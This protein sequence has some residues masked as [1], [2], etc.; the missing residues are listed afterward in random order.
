MHK[1]QVAGHRQE[2]V[3]LRRR[4]R[5]SCRHPRYGR[6]FLLGVPPPRRGRGNA[7]PGVGDA[8]ST[9][10]RRSRGRPGGGRHR[11]RRGPAG[12]IG[13]PVLPPGGARRAPPAVLPVLSQRPHAGREPVAR[14][15]RPRRGGR[16][17]GAVGEGG[18][19]AARGHDAPAR[20]AAAAGGRL[21]RSPGLAGGGDRPVG[22]VEA[23]LQG[24]APPE[25]DRVRQR[26][27]RPAGPRGRS[28]D[29][30]AAG[31]LEPRLRQHRGVA[32]DLADPA[33][34]L[35]QRGRQDRPHGRGV[36]EDPDRGDLHQP[37][38]QLAEPPPRGHAVRHPRGHGRPPRVSRGRGLYLHHPEPGGRDLHP[39]RGPRALHRRG[40]RARVALHRHGR[41]PG[42]GRGAGRASG[43]DPAGEGRLAPGGRHLRGD[44]LPAQSRR[45]EALRAQVARERPGA[46]ADHL[47]GHRRPA[48]PG[49]LRRH[50]GHR[51][52]QHPQGL[53]VPAVPHRRRDVVRTGDPDGPG[54]PRLSAADDRGRPRRPHAVLRG[55]ARAGDVRGRHRAGVAADAGQP[56]VPD[57]GRARAGGRGAG[58]PLPRRGPGARVP[59]VVLPLEQHPGRR[60]DRRG[61][62]GRVARPRRARAAGAPHARRSPVGEPRDELRAAVAVPAEPGDDG[63]G[64]GGVS[65]LGRRAARGVRPRDGAALRERPARGPQ[66]RGPVDR[67][68]HVP[69]RTPGE[70]LRHSPHLRLPLPA[71]AVGR[72]PRL[73]ARVAGTGQLP[74]RHV[75]PEQPHV[76]GQ[77]GGLGSREHPG[78]AAPRA[79]AQRPRARG[80]R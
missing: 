2:G 79:A 38:R 62:P 56:P 74:V 29:A 51:F 43:G 26:H 11:R 22:A 58:P 47:S 31:R 73:S 25:P 13:R 54:P 65:G 46:R 18:A 36:L 8:A 50:P 61:H 32:D 53:H 19:Q 57:P 14:G 76:A 45:G 17:P 21:R 40:A 12:A 66:R 59:A 39:G 55:R 75:G 69:Q 78:D 9:R 42:H 16:Q 71:R 44:Q 5:D 63:A 77:A 37:D 68:L 35:R 15:P 70:A 27:P 30:A 67:R 24:A 48:N 34:D 6:R 10:G 28:G 4:S 60:A 23:G 80:D 33:R 3:A 49:T 72:G 20:R 52:A 64:P 41:L 7:G 1:P